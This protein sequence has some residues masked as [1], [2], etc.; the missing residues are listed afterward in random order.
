MNSRVMSIF[1]TAA[2]FLAAASLMTLGAGAQVQQA[3][4][5]SLTAP[6]VSPSAPKVPLSDEEMG[7]LYMAR[8][9]FR[10]AIAEYKK[11]GSTAALLNKTGIAWHNLGEMDLARKAY[12]RAMKLDKT[13]AEPVNNV[14]TVFYAE[15]RYGTAI[16]RYRKAIQ[17]APGKASF[18]S[19][20]GT[21]Y[22]SQGKFTLMMQAYSKAIEL[23]PEIFE[24]RG[25]TGTE[26]QDRTVADRAQYHYELARIYAKLGRDDLAIQYLRHSLEEGFKDKDKVRKTPEFS[27]LLEKPE[28]IELMASEPRVL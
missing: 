4:N 16:K 20:L 27:G 15:K 28:F 23:D 19:N 24:H 17:L 10:E 7:D 8:K 6:P 26:V 1:R 13:F 5:A 11:A 3:A 21:A 25:I 9:M 14:G 12:E 22:Y 2:P 18:W